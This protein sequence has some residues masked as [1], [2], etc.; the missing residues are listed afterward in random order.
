MCIATTESYNSL[1]LLI[2]LMILFCLC[3]CLLLPVLDV[4]QVFQ[5]NVFC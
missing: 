1:S 5:I 2:A 4:V 3:L